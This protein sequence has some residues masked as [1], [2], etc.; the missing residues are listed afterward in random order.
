MKYEKNISLN[1]HEVSELLSMEES[2]DENCNQLMLRIFNDN[3]RSDVVG[4]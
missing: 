1:E 3:N 2:M 4:Y